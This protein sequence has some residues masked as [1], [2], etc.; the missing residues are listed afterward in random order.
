MFRWALLRPLLAG[1]SL[2]G[3]SIHV[4]RDA[5]ADMPIIFIG[6]G[7]RS[8]KSTYA[9]TRASAVGGRLGFIATAQAHD[10]EM[11]DRIGRHQADRPTQFVTRE[12]PLELAAALRESEA[13]F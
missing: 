10:E 13:V 4:R 1:L 5:I 12:E 7:S 2:S 3:C 11:Q 9:L 6:G 8:G